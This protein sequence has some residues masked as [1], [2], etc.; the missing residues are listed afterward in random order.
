MIIGL[1]LLGFI[2]IEERTTIFDYDVKLHFNNYP[3]VGRDNGEWYIPH[4]RQLKTGIECFERK[5][6]RCLKG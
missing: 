6:I 1:F 2:L 5:G 3:I 4:Y